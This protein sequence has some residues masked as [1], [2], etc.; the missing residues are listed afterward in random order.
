ME[1]DEQANRDLIATW[2][3]ATKKQNGASV[4]FRDANMHQPPGG[5]AIGLSIPREVAAR[6]DAV[7]E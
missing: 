7:I 2:L 5:R 6:A 1:R 4:L 3:A